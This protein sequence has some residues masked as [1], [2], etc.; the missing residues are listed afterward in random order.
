M[1]YGFLAWIRA[2]WRKKGSKWRADPILQVTAPQN[3]ESNVTFVR[4]TIKHIVHVV[5]KLHSY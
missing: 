2:Y 3:Q 5:V 4:L 1:K